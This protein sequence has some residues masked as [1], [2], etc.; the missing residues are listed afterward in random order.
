MDSIRAR[1]SSDRGTDVWTVCLLIAGFLALLPT[2]S[3]A[4]SCMQAPDG[5][6]A[7]WSFDE[8]SGN[9]AAERIARRDGSLANGPTHAAGKVLGSL[10]FDGS[11]DYVAVA[12]DD[13]WAFGKRDFT[14][15][16]WAKFTWGGG[17]S[18]GHPGDV[19]IGND[20]GPGSRAKWFFALGGGVLN[21]HIN[22]PGIGARFFPRV[23]FRPSPG[24]WYHLAVRRTAD[25]YAIFVDGVLKGSAVDKSTIPN[26]RAALTIGQAEGLGFM[27]GQLD[28]VTIYDRALSDAELLAISNAGSA[29]KCKT[30]RVF[31]DRGGDSGYATVNVLGEGIM[32]GAKVKLAKLGATDVVGQSVTVRDG[33]ELTATF[34]LRQK[35]RGKWD[36]VVENPNQETLVARQAFTI[37]AGNRAEVWVDVVGFPV[38]RPN[39]PQRFWVRYGNRGNIDRHDLVLRVQVPKGTRI[40]SVD[41]PHIDDP[42]VDWKSVSLVTEIDSKPT[43][44]TWL[45]RLGA[46]SSDGFGISVNFVN[47]TISNKIPITAELTQ[48]QST[49]AQSGNPVNIPDSPTFTALVDASYDALKSRTNPPTKAQV[50]STFEQGVKL[51]W[52]NFA[53]RYAVVGAGF[54]WAI[55]WAFGQPLLGA[56]AGAELGS[57]VDNAQLAWNFL[58]DRYFDAL[59]VLERSTAG[60]RVEMIGS[61]DPNDK[62]GPQGAGTQ[63]YTSLALPFTYAIRFEN[64]AAATAPAQEVLIQDQLDAAKLD[65]AT[66][67]LGPVSFGRTV[68]TPGPGRS[69]FSTDVDLRPAQNLV[70]RIVA[71]LDATT[72][73][74]SWRFTSLDPATQKPPAD[75]RVGFLPPNKN[76]PE[77]D[78]RVLF[79]VMPKQSLAT[80][81][82]LK[83]KATIVFDSNKPIVTPVW[84]NA[85]DAVRPR[86]RVATLAAVQRENE[87]RVAWSGSD[88]GAGVASYNVFFSPDNGPF[89][90][91]LLDTALT[92]ETFRGESGKTYA[93]YCTARDRAGNVEQKTAVAEAVTRV[94]SGTVSAYGTGC[95]AAKPLTL[96]NFQGSLPT[97]GQPFDSQV[98]NTPIPEPVGVVSMGL[99]N[100]KFG[101]LGLPLDLT[102]LGMSGCWLYQSMDNPRLLTISGHG[103]KFGFQIPANPSFVGGKLYLQA[104]VVAP[105][106]NQFGLVSS[107]GLALTIGK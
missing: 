93:F 98:T 67:R 50:R 40:E 84:S 101:A 43:V 26:P 66:L 36:V 3:A 1:T 27:H 86:S 59:E 102:P 17:G 72:N 38:A 89:E 105:R 49:F 68:V 4:Q 7:W 35:P 23:P 83:N 14:I 58:M 52:D 46:G 65:L 107:N 104:V 61:W 55:G 33:R 78:G 56:V 21:F 28:E 15:E 73:L 6:V 19:F 8:T 100:R 29:G 37:E 9:T 96:S 13:L 53:P 63:R 74:L 77:G 16:L 88:V 87:F 81:T 103:G 47:A 30:M 79:S 42:K 82:V 45:L 69:Q 106:T 51:W 91:W 57:L 75:P 94:S 11:N 76:P 60:L 44:A 97:I 20:E 24:Q 18:V 62:A 54:G 25:T 12:D 5:V 95:P 80:D 34:D 71:S 64:N 85:I 32:N 39:R 22:G 92:S 41:L 70:V 2:A 10:S 48:V 31:P 90:P 99:S